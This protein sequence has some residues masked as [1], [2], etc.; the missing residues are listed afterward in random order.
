VRSAV[1]AQRGRGVAA[2]KGSKENS[3]GGGVAPFGGRR[4][5]CAGP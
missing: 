3:G 2:I 5:L 1:L 4:R